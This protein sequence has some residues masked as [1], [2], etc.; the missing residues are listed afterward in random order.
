[1]ALVLSVLAP[2]YHASVVAK[3]D[4]VVKTARNRDEAGTSRRV[5]ALVRS[6]GGAPGNHRSID[7]QSYAVVSTA[8]N[9]DEAGGSRRVMALAL[10]VLAPG[11]HASVVAKRDAVV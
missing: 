8:R 5:M 3:R 1:M 4:A 6:A 10:S 7:T 2:G 11:Y 9:R